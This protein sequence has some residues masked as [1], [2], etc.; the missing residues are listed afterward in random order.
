[1]VVLVETG[2]RLADLFSE[3]EVSASVSEEAARLFHVGRGMI[4]YA[5]FFY[6]LLDAG[7]EKAF[8]AVEVAAKEACEAHAK[9]KALRGNHSDRTDWL[10]EFGWIDV[11]SCR[12]MHAV[13]FLR[14]HAVH[15]RQNLVGPR[16]VVY[17]LYLVRD[18][19]EALAVARVATSPRY[20]SNT[21]HNHREL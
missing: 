11:A 15:D 17:G 18:L 20:L 19:L 10:C 8:A 2:N 1:M 3:C 7:L 6:P 13:R 14:N 12:S 5:V 4:V 9:P 16:N 21:I